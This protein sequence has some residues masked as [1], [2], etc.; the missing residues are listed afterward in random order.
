M[1]RHAEPLLSPSFALLLLT[2]AIVGLSFST[3]FLLPKYLAVELAADAAT[4]G[5]VSAAALVTSVIFMP[6]AG[7]Q[8]DHH[9]RRLFAWTGALVLA[10]GSAGMLLV[11]RVGP[12][13]WGVRVLQGIAF[14]LFYVAL[15][16]L[17]T[18]IAPRARVGQAIGLFGGIMI[19][20][21][22]LGPAL[23][24]WGAALFGWRAVF[25]ATVVAALLAA[26]LARCLPDPHPPHARATATTMRELLT[27]PGMLRV[28][29][30]TAMVGWGFA[31]MF[32]FHQPWALANG[33]E[34]VSLYLAGFAGSA[35]IM[36]VGLGG[37]ADR[38]GRLRV[39]QISLLLY[40]VAP[41]SLVWLPAL[42]LL[43]TGILLGI[44]HGLFF[45]ALNAVTVDLARDNERGKAM[46]AY[47]GAFNVGFASGSYLQGYLA[48]Q[49]G[50]PAIFWLATAT[51]AVAFGLLATTRRPSHAAGH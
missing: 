9:G 41:L 16:T 4:I 18:D 45:P 39:A 25:A 24:E 37:L 38:L 47:N 22:A 8:V 40:I 31:S 20:T 50:Y 7:V 30:I 33:F 51:C 15:S 27:R 35:M 6:I 42:G 23:A 17:A 26:V 11:D 29:G 44:S 2:T 48:I 28:L 46:A 43:P 13:L 19:A 36:R 3:Y 10:V 21:N 49:A 12:L 34:K 5:A 32:T 14:P 1:N